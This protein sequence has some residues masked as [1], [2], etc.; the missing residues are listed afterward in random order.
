MQRMK[1]REVC[2]EDLS[3]K[4]VQKAGNSSSMAI[5]SVLIKVYDEGNEGFTMKEFD[6]TTKE[7][8]SWGKSIRIWFYRR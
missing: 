8:I 4:P 6:Q 5:V 1:L 7:K 3:T 2:L